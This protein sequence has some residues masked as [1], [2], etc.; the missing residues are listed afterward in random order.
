MHRSNH[1]FVALAAVPVDA[2]APLATT[3]VVLYVAVSG[4]RFTATLYQ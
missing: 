1:H 3:V 2:G 4:R